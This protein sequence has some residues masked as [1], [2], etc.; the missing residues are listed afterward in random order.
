MTLEETYIKNIESAI[1]G[2][3]LGTKKPE[4]VGTVVASNMTKLK[5]VNEGMASD[6]MAKYKRVLEDSK[7]RK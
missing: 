1:R 7:N 5:E 3:K 6:L 4:E 2:I